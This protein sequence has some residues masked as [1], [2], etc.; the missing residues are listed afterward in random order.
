MFLNLGDSSS[1][2]E[3]VFIRLN[4]KPQSSS[5]RRKWPQQEL[6]PMM[7]LHSRVQPADFAGQSQTH[8]QG[9]IAR[10]QKLLLL[11]KPSLNALHETNLQEL[12]SEDEVSQAPRP[13]IPSIKCT[14]ETRGENHFYGP[15][16]H[17]TQ[18]KE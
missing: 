10:I 1:D 16:R 4:S 14:S 3:S 2:S 13:S 15:K 17:F 8:E 11:P 7:Q 6:L 12:E 5:H 18:R 9:Q